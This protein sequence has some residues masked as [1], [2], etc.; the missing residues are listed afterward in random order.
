MSGS[1]PIAADA[2]VSDFINGIYQRDLSTIYQGQV[3]D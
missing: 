3:P 1:K 2:S